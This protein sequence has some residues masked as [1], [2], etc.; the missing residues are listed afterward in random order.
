MFKGGGRL[1]LPRILETWGCVIKLPA[2][3]NKAEK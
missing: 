1:L 3:S 2:D